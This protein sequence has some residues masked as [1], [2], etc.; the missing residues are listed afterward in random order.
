VGVASG[1]RAIWAGLT[2]AL[3]LAAVAAGCGQPQVHIRYAAGKPDETVAYDTA[4]YQ[5]ARDSK[6]QIILF[7][8]TAAPIGE[9]DPGCEMVDLELPEQAKYGWLKDDK[10]PVYRWIR[11]YGHDTVW[12]GTAGQ[13]TLWFGDERRHAHLKLRMTLEPVGSTEDGGQIMSG[14]VKCSEDA[15]R[16]QGLINRYGPWLE[17]LIRP[18]ATGNPQP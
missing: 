2:L 15:V 9:A 12:Q 5:F 10:V 4:T 13:A 1:K 17:S 14:R 6:V 3:G 8:R 16:T 18:S 11:Q 7:R